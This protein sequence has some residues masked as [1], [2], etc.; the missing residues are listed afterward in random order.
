MRQI[1]FDFEI[2]K[3]SGFSKAALPMILPQTA[4][5]WLEKLSSE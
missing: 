2:P 1:A 4:S 5:H 3:F